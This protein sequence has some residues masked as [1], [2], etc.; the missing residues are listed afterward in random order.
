MP[1]CSEC[2]VLLARGRQV[3]CSPACNQR[4]QKRMAAQKRAWEPRS[5]LDANCVVCG[6]GC[7]EGKGIP[8]ILQ[9]RIDAGQIELACPKS[10][11]V[12]FSCFGEW[13]E[14][15]PHQHH[16]ESTGRRRGAMP[17]REEIYRMAEQVREA[18]EPD[19][20]GI[21]AIEDRRAEVELQM[22]EDVA[23]TLGRGGR[24]GLK[25]S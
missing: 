4:R 2:S 11:Y 5:P 13:L 24:G 9:E 23:T 12:C 20:F 19:K 16:S 18:R 8:P 15:M 21:R 14:L 3:T 10:K 25:A 17:T 22:V 1:T 6:D 7:N